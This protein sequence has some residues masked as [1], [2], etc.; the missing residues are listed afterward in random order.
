MM[1]RRTL[2]L[3]DTHNGDE[4]E[5]V[6]VRVIAVWND[7]LVEDW[8][9]DLADDSTLG[10]ELESYCVDYEELRNTDPQDYNASEW[11]K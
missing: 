6:E 9:E 1:K 3:K 2:Q 8:S 7:G 4:Y 5:I 11:G 10:M